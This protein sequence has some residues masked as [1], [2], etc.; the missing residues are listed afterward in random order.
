MFDMEIQP[1]ALIL[2]AIL[3]DPRDLEIIRLLGWYRIPLRS[4]PKVIAVDYIA[5]YQTGTFGK[6]KWR[7]NY[8]APV[9]GYEL[10]T[11]AE[12]FHDQIDHIHAHH[13]YYK[14]QLGPLIT[15]VEPILAGKWK[16]LTFLYTTGEYLIKAKTLND[17]VVKF[18]E[19]RL[20]WN[21]L[22]ERV[23]QA[24]NNHASNLEELEIDAQV[25]KKLLGYFDEKN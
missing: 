12:L 24:Y 5:F 19:R 3:K 1:S 20:L 13:E 4:A 15:L 25:L 7:I 11:R 6:D 14:I 17:L 8:V 2:V 22:S 21:A 9:N 10:T 16:R 18:E 23:G